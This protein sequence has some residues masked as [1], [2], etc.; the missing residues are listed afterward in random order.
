MYSRELKNLPCVKSVITDEVL[1][2]CGT[3]PN[4]PNFTNQNDLEMIGMP[5]SW[6]LT[7][8]GLTYRGDT[9]VVAVIDDGFQL[10]HE[11]LKENLWHNPG[12]IPNDGIDND[13]NG[14]KDDYYGV[15]ITTGRD[16]HPVMSHGTS[17][18]GIIGAK[19][20]N[21]KG[22]SGINWNIKLMTISYDHHISQLV[23]A[24]NYVLD[25]RK[26][27]NDTKGSEGAFVVAVNL[28]SG[29]EFALPQNFPLWCS[30][31]DSLGAQGVLSVCS[32]SNDHHNV[33]IYGDLPAR[34]T[35]P[36]P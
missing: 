22:I 35:S 36:L 18:S 16:N 25:M 7:T 29:I 27:Y 5:N 28:S 12:E 26:K 30:F 34:C 32:A 20:N 10:S 1:Q 13:G 19:G 21:G 3:I 24:Y 14:Y 23:E 17:V 31:Y 9:I 2:D 6:D 4:D 11:D 8:G 15:N 33:E